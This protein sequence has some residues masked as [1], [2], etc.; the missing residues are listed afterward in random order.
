MHSHTHAHRHIHSKCILTLS[1]ILTSIHTHPCTHTLIHHTEPEG[2]PEGSLTRARVSALGLGVPDQNLMTAPCTQHTHCHPWPTPECRASAPTQ[3]RQGYAKARPR[4]GTSWAPGP[5][6]SPPGRPL[7]LSHSALGK[8]L[9]PAIWG[10]AGPQPP[11][12]H[13]SLRAGQAP[14][15]S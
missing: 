5:F 10:L 14:T 12:C 13:V 11:G 4:D 3:S 1:C 6:L 15:L 7:S 9:S 8:H 2:E